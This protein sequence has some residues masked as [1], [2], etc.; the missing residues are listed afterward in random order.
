MLSAGCGVSRM[1]QVAMMKF[2]TAVALLSVAASP[3]LAQTLPST[4]PA[5]ASEE[6]TTVV[7]IAGDADAPATQPSRASTRS[8]TGPS[9]KPLTRIEKFGKSKLGRTA[10]AS[11]AALSAPDDPKADDVQTFQRHVQAGRWDDVA[12]VIASF[13]A[14]DA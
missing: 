4:T 11:L 8:S 9:T 10:Q 2:S 14:K 5:G 7:V 13:D 6:T 1:K 12:K 3:V